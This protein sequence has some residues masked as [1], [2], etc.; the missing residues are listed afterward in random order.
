MKPIYVMCTVLVLIAV[1]M[2]PSVFAQ[3][4]Y[5]DSNNPAGPLMM[6]AWAVGMAT[7]GAVSGVGIWSIVR[8]G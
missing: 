4:S 3:T 1:V 5:T 2:T 8:K 7:A 6:P